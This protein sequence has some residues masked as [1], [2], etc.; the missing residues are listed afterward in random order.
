LT[1]NGIAV[2]FRPRFDRAV[3]TDRISRRVLVLVVYKLLLVEEDLKPSVSAKHPCLLH[4][5]VVLGGGLI[6]LNPNQSTGIPCPDKV[7]DQFDRDLV[8][9]D[10]QGQNKAC[11]VLL[12]RH[13]SGFKL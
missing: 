12:Q 3:F 11:P 7:P 5:V 10:R 8:R 9:V 1:E 2:E 13:L 4:S 6:I